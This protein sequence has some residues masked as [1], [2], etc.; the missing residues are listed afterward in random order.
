[1][2]HQLFISHASDRRFEVFDK[3]IIIIGFVVLCIFNF[4]F[5]SCSSRDT[6]T[7]AEIKIVITHPSNDSEVDSECLVRGKVSNYTG[8]NIFVLVRP[9]E[10][11]QLNVPLWKVQR[12]PSEI[13]D[14]GTWQTLCEIEG[15]LIGDQYSELIAIV[16]DVE[17]KKGDKLVELPKDII[18]KSPIIAVKN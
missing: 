3:K 4:I 17:L 7:K 18:A 12:P 16:I 8:G 14:D 10:L 15:F 11:D 5:F 13:N 6:K 2:D 1:M 9:I